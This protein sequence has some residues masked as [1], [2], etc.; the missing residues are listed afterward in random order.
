MTFACND[1]KVFGAISLVSQ[2]SLLPSH[3]F[4]TSRLFDPRFELSFYLL[5]TYMGNIARRG[6][7]D[8]TTLSIKSSQSIH[9]TLMEMLH[10][11]WA[12]YV[13]THTL[14]DQRLQAVA[15]LLFLTY[16]G[17]CPGAV[18]QSGAEL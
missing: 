11:R 12:F 4:H 1:Q 5:I 16:T 7:A 17:A 6:A 10:Y 8:R 13:E 2:L 9:H 14:E 15:V 18:V 3:F